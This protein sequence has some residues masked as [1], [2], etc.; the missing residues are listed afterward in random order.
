MIAASA[1]PTP[2]I[3]FRRRA[4]TP[5]DRPQLGGNFESVLHEKI[6]TIG[7]NSRDDLI[8]PAYN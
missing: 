4:L 3:S 1:L 2:A 5:S 6:T 8:S 7:P